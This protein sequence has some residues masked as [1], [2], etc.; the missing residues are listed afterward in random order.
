MTETNAVGTP[1]RTRRG[2]DG[3]GAEPPAPAERQ[4]IGSLERGVEVLLLF[5]RVSGDLGVTEV[6][7]HLDMPKT[8]V[9][10]ILTTLRTSGLIDF[11]PGTRRYTLGPA[12]L[13]LGN[14][15]LERIDLREFALEPMRRL[16]ERTNET[17]TLSIR[18]GPARIYLSQAVPDREV[19]MTVPLAQ[20]FPLHVG[21]SSKV[22]LAFAPAQERNDYLAALTGVDLAVLRRELAEITQRGYA[23]SFG[24]RQEG[25][26]SVAAPVFS[27]DGSLAGVMSVCGPAERL[28]PVVGQASALLL[29]E[30]AALSR[31]LGFPV[32]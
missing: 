13:A 10:R 15:Y 14:A 7:A 23:V 5:T 2:A 17:A 32:R 18:S 3:A 28:R 19:R 12:A 21:G 1:A 11:D 8:V 25:A 31:R 9:H 22:F 4:T 6:A 20:P 26:G 27:A 29:M 24:E 16:V 30:T